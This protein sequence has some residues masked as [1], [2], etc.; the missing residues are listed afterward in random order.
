MS[1]LITLGVFVGVILL[2][3]LIQWFFKGMIDFSFGDFTNEAKFFGVCF[4][5]IIGL[6]L[7]LVH[8]VVYSHLNHVPVVL[9]GRIL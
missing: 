8:A 7:Y 3:F 9:F 1:C 2:A 4:I 6:F 5:V